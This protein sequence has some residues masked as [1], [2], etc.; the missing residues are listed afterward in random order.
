MFALLSIYEILLHSLGPQGWWPHPTRFGK[1]VGAILAP[2]VKWSNVEK[3]VEN[4]EKAGIDNFQALN[5]VDVN[6]LE[7]LIKP[8]IYFRKKAKALKCM[9]QREDLLNKEGSLALREELLQ[10]PNIGK[11]TADSLLLY[12]WDY[13]IMV[14]DAYTRRVLYRLGLFGLPNEKINYDDLRE[15]IEKA[16]PKDLY[17]Y[18]EFHALIV[19]L[20]ELYC[21]KKPLCIECPLAQ[22]EICKKVDIVER[23]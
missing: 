11:E 9:A 8:S 20:G 10:L 14:V 5:E 18:Q 13:P 6:Y 23:S 16:L 3:A 17:I 7:E 15:L 2:A 22:K 12:S 21:R 4:L 19:R 1:I